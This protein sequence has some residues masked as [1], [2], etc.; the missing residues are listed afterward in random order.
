MKREWELRVADLTKEIISKLA[1][2]SKVEVPKKNP[3]DE[4]VYNTLVD[5]FN[6]FDKDG[7]GE[8]GFPEYTEAWKFLN[9]PGGPSEIKQTFD[10]VDVDGSGMVAI[11]EFVLS[12]MGKKAMNFGA[13]ADLEVLNTL[14]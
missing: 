14:L 1:T 13:L 6:A 9:R 3:Q 11:E 8:L 4:R 5:T 7:S 10:S 12:L 2:I